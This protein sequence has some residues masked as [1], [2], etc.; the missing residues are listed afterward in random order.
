[1]KAP[2]V[3]CGFRGNL[4]EDGLC[5]RCEVELAKTLQAD[6]LLYETDEEPEIY[7]NRYYE[8]F[9]EY[10]SLNSLGGYHIA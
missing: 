5:T 3:G 7:D 6:L 9:W 4:N 2:C 1:M 10:E 8:E